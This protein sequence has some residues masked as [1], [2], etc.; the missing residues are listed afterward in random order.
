MRRISSVT[1]EMGAQKK[2]KIPF[3]RNSCPLCEI[4]R[5]MH[6]THQHTLGYCYAYRTLFWPAFWPA[7]ERNRFCFI[8]RVIRSQLFSEKVAAVAV[9]GYKSTKCHLVGRLPA[10]L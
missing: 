4:S 3:D 6:G 1:V 7:R 2:F 8:E 5:N 10:S 9:G